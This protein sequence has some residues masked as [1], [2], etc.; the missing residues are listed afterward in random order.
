[1]RRLRRAQDLDDLKQEIYVR[2]LRMERMD[3]V[4]EPLAYLYTIAAN[5]VADFMT[6]ERRRQHVASDSEAVDNWAAD[7]SQAV[8]DVADRVS[9]EL[10]LEQ[11]LNQLPAAQAAALVYHYQGGLSCEEIA[12]KLG[13]STKSVDKY[14]TRAKAKMRLILWERQP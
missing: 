4:R 12:E 1:L 11:A 2:L 7:P 8:R 3:C 6:A 5:V 14:L 13:L 10:Q 9:V